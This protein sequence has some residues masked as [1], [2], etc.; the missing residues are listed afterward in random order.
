MADE[1][2]GKGKVYLVGAGPGDPRLI[3][4]RGKECLEE[5][6]AVVY[7][8]LAPE[9]LLGFCRK[10][11]LKVFVGKRREGNRLS[12]EEINR[13]LIQHARQGKVVVRLK[14][15]DPFIFGRGGEE[16][17]ALAEEGIPF[18]IVPGVTA[19][20]AVPAYAGIPLTHR[21][22]TSSVA[23]ITGHED[24]EK[25]DSRVA[26]DKISTGIGT[27]IFYMG[28]RSLP[29]IIEKLIAHGR[30]PKTPIALVQWGTR[31]LQRT[32]AGTLEDIVRRAEAAHLEPP[33]T[34]VV[35]EVV[36]L[37]EKLDWYER[38]PLFGK[39]ILT[40]RAEVQEEQFANAV[41]A[42]G[43]EAIP[44]PTIKIVS[45][46]SWKS[47][48][49][50]IEAIG[51]FDWL[52]LTSANGVRYFFERLHE[53]KKDARALSGLRICAIGPKTAEVL[54]AFG[55]RADLVPATY[56]AEG[57]LEAFSGEP[58]SGKR[59]LLSRAKV[60]REIL[61]EELRRRG[62]TVTVA[63]AYETIRP[64]PDVEKIERLVAR[65]GIDMITFTSSSTATNFAELFGTQ[66]LS[67]HLDGVPIAAIGPVTAQTL[68]GLGLRCAVVAPEHT[69]EGLVRAVVA[70]FH[71]SN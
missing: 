15:G 22:W 40:T 30:S 29:Q 70:Y 33:V 31:P 43:G 23:F 53:K 27:L 13:L 5:A 71:R 54:S 47:L 55:I 28:V 68:E 61:P 65:R 7:D 10:D 58:L 39:R 69:V 6:D 62:A 8:Y 38:L 24:P 9:Q 45:P 17:E 1:K 51:G 60:A 16:A 20:I 59:M 2:T 64:R 3:T 34:I 12:Q 41:A 42:L 11:V 46:K 14:G 57:V 36:R 63:V 50:A 19:A 48:D 52:I 25:R 67:G 56:T 44:F 35:G 26:W 66:D 49:Q 37:R 32:V 21:D 18:E 4:V